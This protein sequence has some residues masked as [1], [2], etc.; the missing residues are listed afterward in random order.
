MSV[1]FI[2]EKI[3]S[4]SDSDGRVTLGKAGDDRS[5][6]V[7]VVLLVSASLAYLLF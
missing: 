3:S 4:V 5:T 7:E 2:H 6:G 1:E